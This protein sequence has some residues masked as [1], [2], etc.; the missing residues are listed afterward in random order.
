MSVSALVE[1]VQAHL[2]EVHDDPSKGLNDKL[3]DSI[4]RQVSGTTNIPGVNHLV[5]DSY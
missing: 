4:D 3:L 1:E 2:Q 5:A